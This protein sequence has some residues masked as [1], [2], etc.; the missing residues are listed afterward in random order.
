MMAF[1]TAGLAERGVD[2][3]LIA[4]ASDPKF[5]VHC[6]GQSSDDL[7]FDDAAAWPSCAHVPIA[8]IT[9]CL[10]STSRIELCVKPKTLEGTALMVNPKEGTE[11]Q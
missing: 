5:A 11:H 2:V 7:I 3:G 4:S 1:R 6:P 10:S 9:T 8:T